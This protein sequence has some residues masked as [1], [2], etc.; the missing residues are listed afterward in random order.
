M[1]IYQYLFS[2]RFGVV[3]D[4][5]SYMP[6]VIMNVQPDMLVFLLKTTT[7]SLTLA[8]QWVN[9]GLQINSL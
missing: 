2:S 5:V 7:V 3:L 6:K 4:L 1:V 8:L 9:V